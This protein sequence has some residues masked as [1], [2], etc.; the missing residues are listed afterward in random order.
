M[1]TGKLE[2]IL[3]FHILSN[4]ASKLLETVKN[5]LINGASVDNSI[6]QWINVLVLSMH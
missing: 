4:R 6:V 1:L 5:I 2:F 3:N